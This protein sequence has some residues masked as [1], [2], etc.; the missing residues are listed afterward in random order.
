MS[1]VFISYKSEDRRRIQPLV[2]CLQSDGY[3]VWWDEQIG[4]GD[5]WREKIEREL[6]DAGCVIVVWSKHSVGREGAFVREEASRAQHRGVYLP[7]LID[8]VSPPLGFGEMQATSLVGWKGNS[9]DHRYLAVRSG[10]Q[11]L[12]PSGHVREPTPS[13]RKDRRSVL[14]GG[15]VAAAV[16][17]SAGA[18]EFLRASASAPSRSIAVLPFENLSGDPSQAYF[19]DGI[20]EELRNDLSRIGGLRVVARTSCDA[21]RNDAAT[22][23][24]KKLDVGTILTGSVRRSPE[25]IRVSAQLVDGSNGLERW[26]QTYDRPMGDLLTIQT[27]IAQRVAEALSIQLGTRVQLTLGGTRNPSAQDLLLKAKAEWNSDNG[28]AHRAISYLDAAIALDPNYAQAYAERANDALDLAGSYASSAADWQNA[29]I[30]ALQDAHRAIAIAPRYALG[31]VALSHCYWNSFETALALKESELAC[32]LPGDAFDALA[33]YASQLLCM[34]RFSDRERIFQRALDLDPLNPAVLQD[35][36]AGQYFEGR[37]AAAVTRATTVLNKNP[38]DGGTRK[39]LGYAQIMLAQPTAATATFTRIDPTDWHH[40]M[41]LALIAA[42]SGDRTAAMGLFNKFAAKSPDTFYYQSAEINAQ[43]GDRDAAFAS[44]DRC[45]Q[46][47][48]P[49]VTWCKVDPFLEP[50]RGD[51]RLTALANRLGLS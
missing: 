16:V 44:L 2:R 30:H 3:S 47:K 38:G 6:D 4:T 31:H 45:F 18:W 40:L 48:D 49:G 8:S 24:A 15:G 35:W 11:R 33:F 7:V 25:L 20:A 50:L 12:L 14:I 22:I 29:S 19:S 42:H 46:V 37:Y 1:D 17:A 21:V 13:S 27:D 26:S 36:V 9:S 32:N 34:G 10:L 28:D 41:G 43:L 51:A 23:A 39:Y 5:V